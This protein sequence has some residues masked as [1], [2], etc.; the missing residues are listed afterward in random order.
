MGSSSISANL[1]G[2]S[3]PIL[4][5][6]IASVCIGVSDYFG[7]Y[8]TRRTQAVTMVATSLLAGVLVAL[9]LLWVV[10][11]EFASRDVGLG[12]LSGFFIGVALALMYRAM[13][14]SSVA[15]AAPVVASLA[16]SVPLG[17]A[18]V[19]GERPSV[20]TAIGLAVAIAG[21]LLTTFSPELAG[22]VRT[23]LALAAAA[24]GAFGVAITLVGGSHVD[25]GIW[26]LAS[27]RVVGLI[28]ML[29]IATARSVPR[30]LPRRH[31]ARGLASG[32]IGTV[33]VAA[34]IAGTQ[35]GSLG[36]VA[37]SGSMYPA[38]TAALAALLDDD[39]L[40]WWQ[41]VGIG[42]AIVGVSLIAIG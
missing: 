17:Y 25:S 23:G 41:I 28:V 14:V 21:V 13:V 7:R 40:R 30:V 26:P 4:L 35:R 36:A 38:V 24:G 42:A 19:S 9:V 31:L 22:R 11:S 32:V 16:A 33:G 20:V 34:L 5:G 29:I 6:A 37:V 1:W 3:V 15:V 2:L 12:A 27:Q 10:P 8:V 18:I 39:P